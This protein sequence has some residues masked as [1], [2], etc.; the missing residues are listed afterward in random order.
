MLFLLNRRLKLIQHKYTLL[1]FI[2]NVGNIFEVNELLATLHYE[3][4]LDNF[5]HFF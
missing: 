1:T 4:L 3:K 2:A 5:P